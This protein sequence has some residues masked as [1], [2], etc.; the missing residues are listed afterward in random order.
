MLSA[1]LSP[2]SMQ[3]MTN[4]GRSQT[5]EVLQAGMQSAPLPLSRRRD[6]V[7]CGKH[8]LRI[9]AR[10][11][12][13]G[14][15]RPVCSTRRHIGHLHVP[16]VVRCHRERGLPVAVCCWPIQAEVVEL[17]MLSK[18]AIGQ[19]G[20]LVAIPPGWGR[21]DKGLQV[22]LPVANCTLLSSMARNSV[23]HVQQQHRRT[24]CHGPSHARSSPGRMC[25]H[26]A[27]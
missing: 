22:S 24:C 1:I 15:L 19:P 6:S 27:L 9:L 18:P 2:G 10:V 14:R 11:T 3:D 4:T 25:G 23:K 17:E 20:A 13:T 26:R 5:F 16:A 12:V 21:H 7:S 8:W